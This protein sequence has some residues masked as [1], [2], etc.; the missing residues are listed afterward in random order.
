MKKRMV[1]AELWYAEEGMDPLIE[2]CAAWLV[3]SRLGF[4]G[5]YGGQAQ[6]GLHEYQIVNPQTG[7][8][9]T[10]G[11]GPSLAVAMCE[12]ALAARR[13]ERGTDRLNSH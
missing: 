2:I 4:P 3:M 10:S 5:R 8:L 7:S 11:K 6:D 1:E 13:L 9:L 12:A